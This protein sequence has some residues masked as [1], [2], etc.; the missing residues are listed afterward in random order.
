MGTAS[1]YSA[2]TASAESSQ[3]L[4]ASL[5]C[6][7]AGGGSGLKDPECAEALLNALASARHATRLPDVCRLQVIAQ[8]V[9]EEHYRVVCVGTGNGERQK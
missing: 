1:G 6:V 8:T 2:I 5:P 4:A 7:R 3:T 9:A